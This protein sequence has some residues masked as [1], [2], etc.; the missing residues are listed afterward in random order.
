MKTDAMREWKKIKQIKGLN[1]TSLTAA[2]VPFSVV[3]IIHI[4]LV[5]TE[6]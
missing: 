3:V 6:I 1:K 4:C 2:L 5:H